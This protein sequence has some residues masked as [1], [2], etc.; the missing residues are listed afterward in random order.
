MS[1]GLGPEEPARITHRKREEHGLLA[2]E[3]RNSV[4]SEQSGDKGKCS[5]SFLDGCRTRR[6]TIRCCEIVGCNECESHFDREEDADV[7]QVAKKSVSL[8]LR[9]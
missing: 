9:P 4:V 2:H 6:V 7:D 5:P 8:R 3:V 1:V